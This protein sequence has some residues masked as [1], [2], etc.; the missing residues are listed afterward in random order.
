MEEEE[1]VLGDDSDEEEFMEVPKKQGRH[2]KAAAG[3]KVYKYSTSK[4]Y[5]GANGR[6]VLERT[7]WKLLLEKRTLR[8]LRKEQEAQTAKKAETD[9]DEEFVERIGAGRRRVGS[10]IEEEGT[11]EAAPENLNYPK[12]QRQAHRRSI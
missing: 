8:K 4:P 7:G 1:F 11:K 6:V 5:A 10:R 3:S 9:L 2:K 12:R